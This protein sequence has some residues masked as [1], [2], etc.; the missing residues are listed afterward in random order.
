[1]QILFNNIFSFKITFSLFIAS[2]LLFG[3]EAE[4]ERDEYLIK[5]KVA[6]FDGNWI[7]LDQLFPDRV[8]ALDSVQVEAK[9][10][11][12]FRGA[13]NLESFYQVRFKGKNGFPVFPGKDIIEVKVDFDKPTEHSI[14]GNKITVLLRSFIQNRFNPPTIQ[15]RTDRKNI[16]PFEWTCGLK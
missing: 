8:V 1:M 9:E 5:I 13:G 10:E 4:K 6:N 16:H 14:T 3:C 11:Y 7:C 12:E 2:L 15:I